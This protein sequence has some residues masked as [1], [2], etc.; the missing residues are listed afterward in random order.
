MIKM[1]DFNIFIYFKIIKN[2][3]KILFLPN[4]NKI[5]LFLP[6]FNKINLFLWKNYQKKIKKKSKF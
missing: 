2:F 6:N 1:N 5:N 4:F 3:I